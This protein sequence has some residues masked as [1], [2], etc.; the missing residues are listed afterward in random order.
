MIPGP[1][2][3]AFPD[4]S[5]APQEAVFDKLL[6]LPDRDEP[7]IRH[8]SG[9]ATYRTEFTC[10]DSLAAGGVPARL[11]LGRVHEVAEVWLNGKLQG[12][13][14]C[15]PYRF[16]VAG[17]LRPGANQLE[18]RVANLWH[19][20]IVGD[21]ALPAQERVTRIASQKHYSNVKGAPLIESGLLGP[22]QIGTERS[23]STPLSRSSQKD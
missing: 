18:I 8:F 7:G 17:S 19:N 1:W 2:T 14:W 22:V 20:R 12:I 13:A 16:N 21:A 3:V 5:G 6:S 15:S 10:P 23:F 4:G 11:D 9:I